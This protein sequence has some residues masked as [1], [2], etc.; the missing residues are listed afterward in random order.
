MPNVVTCFKWVY[1]DADI[2]INPDLSVDTKRAQ[3][4]ISEYDN[5]ALEAGKRA[6][7]ALG[8][9]HIGLTCGPKDAKKALK[10]ALSRGLDKATWVNTGAAPA[11]T[12]EAAKLLA[13]AVA[14]ME[15]VALVVCAD[16]SGDVFARQTAPRIAAILGWPAV[17]GVV[18]VEVDGSA[19]VLTR[20]LENT[21]EVLRVEAPVV[22]AVL[23]EINDAP[24]PGLQEVIKAGKKEV[25][26][27]AAADLGVQ[28]ASEPTEISQQGSVMDR[29]TIVLKDG[30]MQDKVDTLVR[31]LRKEGVL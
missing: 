3:K 11:S 6:A 14:Q 10:P 4:K 31:D 27:I 21:L 7:A 17:T 2:R 15:D 28:P 1:D 16:G 22:I 30:D 5:N 24:L 20:K 26:E 29:K 8:G 23:P 18:K 19:F 13:A 9:Q 25:T 12:G